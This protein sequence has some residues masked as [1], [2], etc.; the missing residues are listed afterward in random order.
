MKTLIYLDNAPD[1]MDITRSLQQVGLDEKES[2]VYVALL[3]LG[4]TTTEPLI[5]DVKLHRQI[6]YDTLARLQDKGLV[7]YLMKGKRKVFQAAPPETIKKIVEEKS[8]LFD[9]IFPQLKAMTM[10]AETEDA[11]I[12]TGIQGFKAVLFDVIETLEDG[13]VMYVIGAEV[14]KFYEFTK[15]YYTHWNKSREKKKIQRKMVTYKT[16]AAEFRKTEKGE[17]Y[18]Q[19]RYIDE[20]LHTPSTVWIYGNKTAIVV[21]EDSPKIVLIKSRPVSLAFLNYFNVLWKIARE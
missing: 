18:R 20:E 17:K 16:Q 10:L 15:Y 3:K 7:T 5:K 13:E 19:T 21:Y 14:D 2:M 1:S 12:Y 9:D 11:E 6:V 8:K 4:S